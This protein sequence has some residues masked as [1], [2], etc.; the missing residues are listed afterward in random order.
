[1]VQDYVDQDVFNRVKFIIG[2]VLMVKTDS[3]TPDTR[4]R[5]DLGADSLDL[6]TLHMAFEEEFKGTLCEEHY[7]N[8]K[9]R[10]VAETASDIR[11]FMLN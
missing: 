1:M 9:E 7:L 2:E 5:K 6:I 4:L 8:S 10:T 11:R 3:I